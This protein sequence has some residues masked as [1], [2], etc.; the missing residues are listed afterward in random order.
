MSYNSLI[1]RDD[2]S[3]NI[4]FTESA[5]C[6]K[7]SALM[8]SALIGSV[9]NATTQD[10][11][12]EAQKQLKRLM[13]Q[14]EDSRVEVK[15]PVWNLCKAIDATA[16]KFVTELKAEETR[17]AG[18]VEEYQREQLESARRAEMERQH[19]LQRIENER[20]AAIAEANRIAQEAAIAEAMAKAESDRKI[21]EAANSEA[22]AKAE[23]EAK[24]QAEAAAAQRAKAEAE[25]LAI[26]AAAKKQV[27]ALPVVVLPMKA[28]G[29]VVRDEFD[30]EV[31]D[32]WLLAKMSPGLVKIE[33][34]RSEI[35][36]A[37]KRGIRS[38]PGL[39]IFPVV[40][41]TVRLKQERALIEV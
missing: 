34:S 39:R 23:A 33:A 37:I 36:E 38:I 19:E 16:A 8:N 12:V 27:E 31:V 30:F 28:E 5:L 29:Q 24:A 6:A 14:V 41:S 7:A 9:R 26:D 18:L 11:A 4:A 1:V 35:K 3:L 21:R 10:A 40:K 15:G 20:L 25:A 2:S 17:I 32:I 22:R 13:K